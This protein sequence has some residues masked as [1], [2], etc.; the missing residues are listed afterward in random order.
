MTILKI[1]ILI[2]IC[3][4][5]TQIQLFGRDDLW[6]DFSPE[7]RREI[8]YNTLD[9]EN[10]KNFFKITPS[11]TKAELSD[12]MP[13]RDN[14]FSVSGNIFS[15]TRFQDLEELTSFTK[16]VLLYYEFKPSFEWNRSGKTIEKIFLSTISY[17]H[18]EFNQ[19]P[20]LID[21]FIE[22]NS[23]IDE[24][25]FKFNFGNLT[26]KVGNLIETLGSGDEISF[27]DILNPQRLK[28]GLGITRTR[29]KK[30]IPMVRGRY[31]FGDN[32]NF[33]TDIIPIF[34]KSELADSRSIWATNIQK[35]ILTLDKK[36]YS[37]KEEEKDRD[38]QSLQYHLSLN[39][40]SENH[41]LRIHIFKL[42]ENL[43][44]VTRITPTD[45][46]MYYPENF[47]LA[48]DG[49]MKVFGEYLLRGEFAYH[50]NREFTSLQNGILGE[51]YKSD[52]FQM[53]LGID[54]QFDGDLY[55][56]VQYLIS[57]IT[58]SITKTDIQQYGTEIMGSLKIDKSFMK[59]IIKLE[60]QGIANFTSGEYIIKPT[61]TYRPIDAWDITIGYQLNDG[62]NYLGP[63]SQ[64]GKE[65]HIF[66][67]SN[68]RF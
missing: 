23:Y 58:N 24:A 61:I 42:F 33:E 37:I 48:I 3:I 18:R 29:S 21:D 22:Y 55:F 56:N 53:L 49:N 20:A 9:N 43:P 30:A 7:L 6:A 39:T 13:D 17:Y 2:V 35:Q 26:L 47:M 66:I 15:Q 44:V 40:S 16:P 14:G 5:G 46:Y 19:N 67:E 27:L 51:S 1:W 52:Q 4:I 32:V 45:Y 62:E 41:E 8:E 11:N 59:D 34:K 38:L 63:I 31:Y 54:H 65:N 60:F 57:S 50:P 68:L 64:Y 25:Y 12:F 10:Y 36:R 28:L